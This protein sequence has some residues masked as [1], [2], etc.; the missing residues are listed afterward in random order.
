MGLAVFR[1]ARGGVHAAGGQGRGREEQ[2]DDAGEHE[3]S[4]GAPFYREGLKEASAG[5]G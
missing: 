3:G 1:V 2:A 4:H 5:R